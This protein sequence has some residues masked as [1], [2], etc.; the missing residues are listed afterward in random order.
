MKVA[1]MSTGHQANAWQ[2]TRTATLRISGAKKLFCGCSMSGTRGGGEEGAGAGLRRNARGCSQKDAA[3]NNVKHIPVLRR[4]RR[5]YSST[6]VA[7][8]TRGLRSAKA[9]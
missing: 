9:C 2:R 6:G 7:A 3:T 5:G 8:V 1:G 4:W